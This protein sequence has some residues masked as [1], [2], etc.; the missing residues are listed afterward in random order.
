MS[1]IDELGD[2]KDCVSYPGKI[3]P[4]KGVKFLAEVPCKEPIIG[5]TTHKKKLYVATENKVY[6][7]VSRFFGLKKYFKEIPTK[8]M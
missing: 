8:D 4:R 6:V 2:S 7:L 1:R 3:E 5:M